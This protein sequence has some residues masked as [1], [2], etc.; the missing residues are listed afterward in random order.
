MAYHFKGFCKHL[1]DHISAKST[2]YN[3][4]IRREIFGAYKGVCV[5]SGH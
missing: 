3:E 2:I 5:D 1:N 4:R